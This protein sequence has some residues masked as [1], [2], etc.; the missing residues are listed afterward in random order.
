MTCSYA[1]R[2]KWHSALLYA[3][4]SVPIIVILCIAYVHLSIPLM[5]GITDNYWGI[6]KFYGG[7]IARHDPSWSTSLLASIRGDDYNPSGIVPLLP[8]YFLFGGGRS[9][10]ICAV[11]I[12]YLLPAVVLVSAMAF[13][14]RSSEGDQLPYWIV[15]ILAIT[16]VPFWFPTLRGYL[17]IIGLI[18][19]SIATLILFKTDFLRR[20]AIP[21]AIFIGCLLWTAFLFR[22]WY[23]FSAIGFLVASF[24]VGLFVRWRDDRRGF[25]RSSFLLAISLAF[26]GIVAA[27]LVAAFQSTLATRILT[28]SYADSFSAYQVPLAVHL[29]MLVDRLSILRRRDHFRRSDGGSISSR[30]AASVLPHCGGDHVRPFHSDANG[31]TAAFPADRNVGLPDSRRRAGSIVRLDSA[32]SEMVRE[33]ARGHSS[34]HYL[35]DRRIARSAARRNGREPVRSIAAAISSASSALRGVSAP[36]RRSRQLRG[37]G[38]QSCRLRLKPHLVGFFAAGALARAGAACDRPKPSRWDG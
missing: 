23:A 32:P 16:F 37:K 5:Y 17:D 18:S 35:R 2:M 29:K 4:L 22:R 9:V 3:C 11:S 12:M 27:G 30:R 21:S 34:C 14:S 1:Q 6:F 26:S 19:L 7:M 20:A 31:R 13:Q 24:M 10:Y 33:T 38:P 36:C 8:I 28:T 15:F 25:W